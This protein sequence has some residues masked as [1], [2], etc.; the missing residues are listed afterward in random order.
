[1]SHLTWVQY[2]V[3]VEVEH[4]FADEAMEGPSAQETKR[5]YLLLQG[6]D[7]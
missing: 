4:D 6:Q 7:H 1:M 5:D 2:Y 3:V